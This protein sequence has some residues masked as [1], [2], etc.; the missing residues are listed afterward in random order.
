MQLQQQPGASQKKAP[1]AERSSIALNGFQFTFLSAGPSTGEPVL[2]LHG[3]PQFADVWLPLME[4]LGAAGFRAVALDQR[5]YSVGAR[6]RDV[7]AYS[8]QELTSDVL[9][10]AEAL[11]WPAFHLVGHDWGGFL[12]WKL[13]AE[14]PGHIRSLTA[15]STAH[16]DAFL[17]AVACDPDQKARSQYISFFKMPG[18]VAEATFL[19]EDAVRL[20]GV[21]QGKVPAQQ[22]SANVR[23]LSQ[24]GALTAA[25]NWYRA[26]DLNARVG[27]VRAPTLYIWGDQDLAQGRVAAENTAVF[28]RGAYRFET[29]PGYSHWLQDEAAETIS[30]LILEHL[31]KARGIAVT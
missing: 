7:E 30:L 24:P 15:L 14:Q 25:L 27:P 2:L 29:L 6:P 17:D 23:R 26:L 21:Y 3:F 19:K 13:A 9:A 18:N 20:R 1:M 12:A 11:G 5:G 16:I 22:V 10:L 4:V 31:E 8:A 28:V